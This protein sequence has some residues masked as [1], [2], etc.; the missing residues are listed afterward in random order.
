MK[1]KTFINLL[2]IDISY[3]FYN[4]IKI[5]F[6]KKNQEIIIKKLKNIKYCLL[7]KT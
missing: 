1:S 3:S 4:P 6:Q 5:K 2:Y 7:N